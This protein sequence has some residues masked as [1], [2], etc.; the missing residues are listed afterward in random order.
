MNTIDIKNK[1]IFKNPWVIFLPFLI[2]YCIYII[3]LYH[4]A[5]QGD[6]V[7]HIQYAT[8]LLHGFYSPPAPDIR[9]DVGP[10]YPLFLAFFLGLHIPL[11][12]ACLM[13]AVFNYLG[14]VFL[15]KALREIVSFKIALIFCIFLGCYY[16][17]LE[18][19][20]LMYAESITL[21]L[22]SI[23][24]FLL[25]KSFNADNRKEFKKYGLL[26][27]IFIGYLALTKI[28]FG[29][30]LL[31]ILIGALLLWITQKKAFN[32]RRCS[33]V[34]LIAL[35]TTSPYLIYTY[36]LSGRLFY[37]GASGGINLYWM[38]SPFKGEYGNWVYNP[39]YNSTIL[40]EPSHHGNTDRKHMNNFIPGGEDSLITHHQKDFEKIKNY[41]GVEEDDAY[42]KIVIE[43]I[44]SHPLKYIENCISNVGRILFNY[45]YSYTIQKPGTLL[46]L[47]MNG[48]IIVLLL[49][50]FI[51]A[52][53]NWR[54]L[55][56]AAR[57]ILLIVLLY[58]FGTVLGSAETRM[59][60]PMVPML[61]FW[62][63]YVLNKAI[64]VKLKFH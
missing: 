57:L 58:F 32:Y 11:F 44:K 63:A 31:I 42:K 16:N 18:F 59:F 53:I 41:Y 6:E 62:I 64:K 3:I 10:G 7:R 40:P 55:A 34:F 17:S 37:W 45:P 4:K 39:R 56:F 2:F 26:A 27:G 22:I 20:A 47:P 24:A 30:V 35:A 29:Y 46:R 36:H 43:N 49:F 23:I 25:V 9:L 48:I 14:I 60:T 8:N 28:I 51:P 1:S 15:F 19:I 13:N 5:L 54:R 50:S 21:F 61:L 33:I 12:F 38:S 52:F